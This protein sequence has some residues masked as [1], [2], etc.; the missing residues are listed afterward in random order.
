MRGIQNP[1]GVKVRLQCKPHFMQ[2]RILYHAA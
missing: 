1:I 2:A